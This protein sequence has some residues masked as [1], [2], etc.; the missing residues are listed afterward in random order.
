MLETST[1]PGKQIGKLHYSSVRPTY[2]FYSVYKLPI[3]KELSWKL[4]QE[5]VP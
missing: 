5:I 3:A 4:K 1:V 2:K